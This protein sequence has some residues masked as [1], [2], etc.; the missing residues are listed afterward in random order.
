MTICYTQL[1][2]DSSFSSS[3]VGLR[4]K[5]VD[6]SIFFR[7]SSTFYIQIYFHG[8]YEEIFRRKE[9]V[10]YLSNHQS[11]GKMNDSISINQ[12]FCFL[13]DWIIV[14]MLAVRQGSLGHIRYVLKNDLK[15]IPFYGFYFEQVNRSMKLFFQLFEPFFSTVAFTSIELI[16]KISI[17]SRKA[18]V[19]LNA[20]DCLF[21][22]LSFQKVLVIIQ[23]RTLMS[24]NDHG[25]SQRRKVTK[26]SAMRT[27]IPMLFRYSA[28]N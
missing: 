17:V 6:R 7:S 4:S 24:L 28:V 21:G 13:V 8:D 15:R 27:I 9:S 10:L 11:S 18:C 22:L 20:M 14:N 1:I 19:K 26:Q 12:E 2:N 23:K 16:K 3:K 25:S 5:Y